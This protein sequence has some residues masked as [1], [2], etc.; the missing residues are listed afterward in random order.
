MVIAASKPELAER[1]VLNDIGPEINFAAPQEADQ[2]PGLLEQE[3]RNVSEALECYKRTYRPV[4]TLPD[5]VAIELV[6]NSTRLTDNGLFRWKTDPRVQA[7][8]PANPSTPTPGLW[9]LFEAVKAP[10]LVIRGA[11]SEALLPSTVSKMCSRHPA[12]TAVEVPGV[13]HTP[14]LSEP[15][16]MAALHGFLS[17]T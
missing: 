9:P 3:F 17:L 16:A 5:D 12:T 8:A 14:W 11:E 10:I 13:G 15:E 1:V 2:G 6:R 7:V 4:E